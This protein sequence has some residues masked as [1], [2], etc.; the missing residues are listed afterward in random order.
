MRLKVYYKSE[1][2][3]KLTALF[4]AVLVIAG[5]CTTIK[6]VPVTVKTE[7]LPLGDSVKLHEG[8]LLYSL[9]LTAFDFTVVAEKTTQT[10]GPYH[11]YADQFLGLKDVIKENR[12]IWTIR[13]VNIK[14]IV[15]IDPDK[16]YVIESDGLIE[17]NALAL[18]KAGLILDINPGLYSTREYYYGN[19]SNDV[20][21][22]AIRDM[23]SDSYY[24]IEQDT[25]YRVVE[26]DTA[27]VRIPYVLERRRQLTLEEQAENTA[28]ILLELREGRHLILTGEATVFPQDRAAIDEINR[29][30]EEYIT[31]FSGKSSTEIRRFRFFFV[32]EKEME[33]RPVILFRFSSETGVLDAS[34][35]SGR[36]VVVEMITENKVTN[37]NIIENDLSSGE[38]YNKLFYRVPEVVNIRVTDGRA[39]L[40]YSR[41]LIYQ[42]GKVITLPANYILR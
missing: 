38:K 31:L 16:Y 13:Q 3:K 30:E 34:D 7:I 8:S 19:F 23:G 32:P 2:M 1:I 29:L 24:D 18:R 17:L 39:T 9:P 10:A 26:L 11:K 25:A 6:E 20:K 37:I 21:K 4:A 5:A 41:Q 12:T 33:G 22:S 42:F 15:E 14:P 27:F 35:I 28:R 40:G 36:P